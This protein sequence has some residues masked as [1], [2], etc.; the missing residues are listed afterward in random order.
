M[1]KRDDKLQP[2]WYVVK[3]PYITYEVLV[4]KLPIG[5]K[6][7]KGGAKSALRSIQTIT[8]KPPR[9]LMIDLGI[10]DVHITSPKGVGE[11][12]AIRYKRDIKQRTRGHITVGKPRF[13]KRKSSGMG[14]GI[15]T[16]KV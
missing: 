5:V 9:E 13:K 8:G 15:Q 1:L 10:M 6:K 7:V 12:G 14:Q 11:P 4:G 16:V 3:S 2:V